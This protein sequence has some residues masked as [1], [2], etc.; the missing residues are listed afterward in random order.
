[1]EKALSGIRVLDFTRLYAGPF[2]TMLLGDL[3][4]D[5]VK[6][7]APGGD[8]IRHQG[9]PFHGGHSMS[10]LAVNR[11]K[12]SIVLDMK[13]AEG[14][15]TAHRLALR[16]DVI[17]EN[18]RP[19]VMPRLGLG[20]EELAARNPGLVYAAMSGLGADGP[21]RDKGA[22]DLT[23]QAEGGY[24]SITGERDGAPIKLGTS[25]FDLICGQ[26]AMGAIVTALFA[27]ARTGK[28]QR[29]E[30]SL[31]EGQVSF[32]VDAAMEWLIGGTVRGK[33][34]SEHAAQVPYKAFQTSDGWLVIA[35]GMQ[36]LFEAFLQVIGRTD[37]L[38]D[39]RF[40]TLAARVANRD[41]VH[42]VLDAEVRRHQTAAL[43]AAL[44]HAN[45][46]C[47]LVNDIRSV[48]EHRQVLH[49]GMRQEVQHPGYGRISMVG[50]A[51]KYSGFDVA[52]DW[53]APPNLGEDQDAVLRDW[54]TDAAHAA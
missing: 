27:R 37:L 26:Y 20:Y 38:A 42:D 50:P 30:T 36:K 31:L 2:C 32:L 6:V 22:F 34:G 29:V 10:Y 39:V 45:V 1:M 5:V 16:A 43:H 49:R 47:A 53:R 18:F 3:G 8:P 40:A 4:A 7:E 24:M 51:V 19:D 15:A 41:A 52:A 25:A 13:S 28:G 48:F 21:D 33:W 14:R 46:P 44:E 54:L 11:N 12:R 17:V 9:P 35:A 23:I